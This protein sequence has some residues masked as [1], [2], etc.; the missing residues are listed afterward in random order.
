MASSMIH[1]AIT[2]ELLKKGAF[3]RWDLK[4]PARLRVG[5]VLPDGAVR[6]NSHLKQCICEGTRFHYDLEFYREHYGPRMR[7]DALYLGYYLHLVQ[8]TFFRNFIYGECHFDSSVPGNVE[9]LHHDYAVT[10]FAVAERYGV[11]K[12]MV[13][14]LDL[15]GESINELAEFDVPELVREVQTQFAPTPEKETSVFTQTMAQA[16]VERSVSLCRKELQ[17]LRA[18]LPGLNSAEWSWNNCG[19]A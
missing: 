17:D 12:T 15:T 2:Q 1:L 3:A 5:A 18:G 6:G 16:L 14:P 8:D 7:T 19:K 4:D 10:N 11:D 9:K 13:V